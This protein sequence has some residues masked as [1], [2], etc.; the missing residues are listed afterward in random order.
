MTH[1]DENDWHQLDHWDIEAICR[2]EHGN[3]FNVL[4]AHGSG[5]HLVV[6]AW[7]P[8]AEQVALL[9]A[10]DGHLV[11]Q[12]D[13]IDARGLFAG[14]VPRH[15]RPF[16]YRLDVCWDGRHHQIDDPYRFPPILT[17]DEAWLL[18]EGNLR[19]AWKTLGAHP[20]EVDGV[21]G[22]AFAV[23][24]PNAK[25][26][27]VVGEFNMWDGRRHPMRLR[28]ECGV[29]EIFLPSIATGACY[30]YEVLDWEGRR[31]FKADPYALAAELRPQTASRV[32]ALPAPAGSHVKRSGLD[33]PV[34]IYEVHLGSWRRHGDGRWLS[35]RELAESL[36]PYV[37]D[38]GFTHIEL[39][40]VNE[41]P[42][43]GSWG[44]QPTG[45]FAPTSRFGGPDDFAALIAAAH[46][47]GLGILLDW[48]PG[49]FPTDA[50]GLGCFDGTH[51]YEHADPREGYH[52]DW[53]TLIYNWGRREVANFLS[54]NALF[55]LE[56]YGVDGLRV[57]AV[58][59]M[60]YRD[61]S[62]P[63]GEWLPNAH[64]GRE[65]LEAIAFLRQANHWI[66]VERP[67]AVTIAEESTVF[68][69]VSRPPE[70]GGLGFH[71]KWNMGWMHDTLAYM[72]RDPVHRSHHHD[73][74]SF[75]ISY[76]FSENYI[77]PLSHDEVVH[78]KGSL[79][80]KMPGDD[81][82][83]LANLRAYFGFM[84]AHPGKKLLFMGGEFGQRNEWN[85][86]AELDWHLLAD[87]GHAGLQA[88]VKA[89][90]RFYL[91]SPPLY[92]LDCVAAGFEWAVVDDRDN[93]VLAFFRLDETGGLVLAV[94]NFT[95]V[96]RTDYRIGV[97]R[98]GR[99]REALNSDDVVFGGSGVC[100]GDVVTDAIES[101]GRQA[102]VTLTLAPLAVQFFVWE[103]A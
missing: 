14:V 26:V 9:D 93:S 36:V 94:C 50:H 84:W 79:L 61:Y 70:A 85:H 63:E 16:A 13:P 12:L 22:V 42:F 68:P 2:G 19:R 67:G 8:N 66:G 43:D 20:R 99:W 46:A 83:R 89:L 11:C 44:Y 54:T 52:R 48:V 4:G 21:A 34:A 25:R 24:A 98:T 82:Q 1:S 6:R 32:F 103:P 59:S 62:R 75:G 17:A 56:Q 88:W 45:L 39:M 51:L 92:R 87:D 31:E 35:Y 69:E 76:A 80:S 73:E 5:Q 28:R 27:S 37:A 60:L 10:V 53:H 100:C 97:L 91:A 33:Q 47:A 38:L 102:S 77:L 30:K 78:G 23:W 58:A 86:D 64:G 18:A 101:H 71:Y 72:Q 96:V 15:A 57:D 29:W 41:H 55:W 65:N 90:N 40:P 49:H 3:A 81:W 74:M 7:L 95:P